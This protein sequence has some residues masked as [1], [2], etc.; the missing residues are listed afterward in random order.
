MISGTQWSCKKDRRVPT[1]AVM[2]TRRPTAMAIASGAAAMACVG[3]S[4][5]VSGVLTKAPFCTAEAVRYA[6]A[7]LLLI[8]FSRRTGRPVL[9]PRPAEWLWLIAVAITGLVIFNFA[10]VEGS[11][12]A[13]PAVLGVAV[14]CVPSMLAVVGPLMEG[15]RPRPGTLAAAVT[16]TCG[17]GLV[18]GVGRSDAIGIAWA[19]VVFASECGFTLLAMPVLRRH[20]PAGVSVH[21]TWLAAVI[22]AVAGLVR[23]GPAAVTQITTHEWLAAAYLAVAVTA[24]AFVLWYSCVGRLG[25]SR[26]G[27]LTGVAPVAAAASGV[28]LGG[29]VPR[30]PVWAGIAV[31]AL[32]LG[33]G[34]RGSTAANADPEAGEV[35]AQRRVN[36]AAEIPPYRR[37]EPVDD[38]DRAMLRSV[39]NTKSKV[40][41]LLG[42][43]TLSGTAGVAVVASTPS[44]AGTWV[45]EFCTLS[46]T[47]NLRTAL[48]GDDGSYVSPG[49]KLTY[50]EHV[51]NPG[52]ETVQELIVRTEL[53]SHLKPKDY[54]AGTVVSSHDGRYFLTRIS[55]VPVT[56]GEGAVT[57]LTAIVQKGATNVGAQMQAWAMEENNKAADCNL[58]EPVLQLIRRLPKGAPHTGDGSMATEVVNRPLDAARLDTARLDTARQDAA[59]HDAAR[60]DAARHDAAR[61]DAT[62]H[63]AT[64]HDETGDDAARNDT[65]RND[66]ARHDA[67]RHAWMRHHSA[68]PTALALRAIDGL[69]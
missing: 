48:T 19:F 6:A 5:A 46:S 36:G 24:V 29:P 37:V 44:Y 60:H 62:R 61:H 4:V 23:E 15:S 56:P 2:T 33:L 25:A 12:Y 1:V 34:M 11:R 43:L 67:R 28:L 26:A 7:C 59:R 35:P 17:A 41:A 69:F 20:G 57:T 38:L 13:E 58:S 30:P 42:C 64:R 8:A 14:A 18:Q 55:S 45:T 32:G 50:L 22:F 65:A 10:L 27:L 52:P 47:Q 53:S 40:A 54:P 39:I 66:T 49:Q 21:T 3:G 9:L 63:D 16:V 31:V 68:A 51:Y